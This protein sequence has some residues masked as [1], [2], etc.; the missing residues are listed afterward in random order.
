M[1]EYTNQLFQ[2]QY[3][4]LKMILQP[5]YQS[6]ITSISY[7][8]SNKSVGKPGICGEYIIPELAIGFE[9]DTQE[10]NTFFIRKQL[11]SKESK[12][13]HHY[14][15]LG[16]A[17]IPTPKYYGS[18]CDESKKEIIILEYEDEIIDENLFF[19]SETNCLDFIDLAARFSC[20][21]PSLDYLSLIGKD[22]GNKGDTRDWKTWMPWSIYILDK[23]WNLALQGK[24]GNELKKLCC[25]NTI[26][27]EL[28]ET[29]KNLI[30][31]INSYEFG[32]VH[33]DF[34]PNNTIRLK[35]S[36]KLGLIDF[37]DV[38][39]DAK[40]Y[41]IARFL[42]APDPRFKM[43][44]K[45]R[46][47]YLEYFIKKI[48]EYSGNIPTHELLKKELFHIWYTRSINLWEY[49]PN[50]YGGPSYDYH[51]SGKNEEERCQ[52]LYGLLEVLIE[53]RN[54]IDK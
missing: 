41:D 26:K 17:G 33:S 16:K 49:L 29:A 50:E 37:E 30:S 7:E 3:S 1:K 4:E 14:E 52:S 44:K 20:L 35:H 10:I 19:S 2:M 31:I 43:D 6:E 53:Y 54:N 24:L 51:P 39:V 12:Q 38:M 13:A 28:Q 46:D 32:I 25:S 15:Y 18:M 5:N 23:I 27:I 40:Y 9:N 47:H 22:M 42:G 45:N 48:S 11:D 8:T 34:R 36:E 21:E